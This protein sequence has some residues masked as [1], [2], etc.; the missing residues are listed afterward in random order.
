MNPVIQKPDYLLEDTTPLIFDHVFL[1]R[2]P[3]IATMDE[4]Q[5]REFGVRSTNFEEYD[6]ELMNDYVTVMLTI[7][8]M[9]ELYKRGY[10]IKAVDPNDVEK[11][12]DNISKHLNAWKYH[13]EHSMHIRNAP[14]I[15]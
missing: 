14:T 9:V 7:D 11:I 2:V 15:Q 1:V 12:Y 6:R 10:S 3:A 5:I 13:L 8:R 4:N